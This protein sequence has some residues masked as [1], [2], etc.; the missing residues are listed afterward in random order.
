MYCKIIAKT[1]I[2]FFSLSRR[3][4]GLYKP[5]QD[6]VLLLGTVLKMW[7]VEFPREDAQHTL[8]M[9]KGHHNEAAACEV[10]RSDRSLPKAF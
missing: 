10:E 8:E 9:Y 5:C 4:N 2:L 7:R 1:E 3:S 6:A